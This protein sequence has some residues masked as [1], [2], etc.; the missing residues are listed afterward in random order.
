MEVIVLA[1]MCYFLV[2]EIYPITKDTGII[3]YLTGG[4]LAVG[5]NA[6][7]EQM[8]LKQANRLIREYA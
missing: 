2:D 7:I 6:Y 5:D 4:G 3:L 8:T 1:Q